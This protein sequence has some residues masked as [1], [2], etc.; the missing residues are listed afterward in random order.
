ML[1]AVGGRELLER[2]YAAALGAR[3]PLARVRRHAPDPPVAS[4]PTPLLLLSH[5]TRIAAG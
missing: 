5:S 4:S 3:L 2:S 1:E